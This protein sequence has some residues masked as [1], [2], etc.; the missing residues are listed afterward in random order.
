[1]KAARDL[2][3]VIDGHGAPFPY[4]DTALLREGLDLTQPARHGRSDD[5]FAVLRREHVAA[6][7]ALDEHPVL[8]FLDAT[9]TGRDVDQLI[10]LAFAERAEAERPFDPK[11]RLEMPD[12]EACDEC[13]RPTFLP[14]GWDVFGGTVSAGQCIA[15]AYERTDEEAHERAVNEAITRAV[16]DPD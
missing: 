6:L 15:C 13:S 1:M 16:N 5:E 8:R 14:F 4:V 12:P 7:V 9:S 3:D 11:D 2:L 10:W